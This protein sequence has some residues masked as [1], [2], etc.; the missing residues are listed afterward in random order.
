M[1]NLNIDEFI[2]S[3]LSELANTTN[4]LQES[5]TQQLWSSNVLR[6][7]G[8][9]LLGLALFDWIEILSSNDL[10]NFVSQFQVMGELIERLPVPLIGMGLV[11]AGGLDNRTRLEIAIL[12]LLSWLSLLLGIF[13]ILLI[14]LGIFNTIQINSAS[15]ASINIQYDQKTSQVNEF[16]KQVRE[17]TPEKIQNIL[18]SQGRTINS[19]NPQE[20]KDKILSEISQSKKKLKTQADATKSKQMKDRLKK[21]V[22]WS[23]AGLL[24]GVLFISIWKYTDWVRIAKLERS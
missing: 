15:I 2:N 18:K 8:Y 12:N 16:E 22:K 9:G 24:S 21:S 10:R 23:L 13:F 11:F 7:L 14:P 17:A 5:N 3:Q 4:S 1:A 19:K 6:I 20:L